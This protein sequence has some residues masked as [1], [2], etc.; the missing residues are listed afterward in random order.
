MSRAI[1]LIHGYLT[2]TKDFGR[3]YDYLGGY[4]KVWPLELPGHNGKVD[5]RKFTVPATLGA[6]QSAFDELAE[7]Y[8]EVDVVGFSMGGALA[9]M[10]CCLRKVHR[11]VLISPANKFLNGQLPVSA[12]KFYGRLTKSAWQSATGLENK[13]KA[14]EQ[15]WKPYEENMS[16]SGKVAVT[17]TFRYMTPRNLHVFHEVVRQCNVWVQ[18]TRSTVPT[19]VLWGMLDEL[20]PQKSPQFV[21]ENFADAQLKIYPDVGHAMLYTNRDNEIIKDVMDFLTEGNFCEEVPP[22]T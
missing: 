16:A 14:L 13:R 2:T 3:L 9:S 7:Q 19:L 1:L 4:D 11:A 17:R 15:A 12:A 10:L 8:D 22:R 20:V 21:V 5:L 6:V 18:S